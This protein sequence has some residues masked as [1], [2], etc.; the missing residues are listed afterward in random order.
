MS[1]NN[2]PAKTNPGGNN[3]RTFEVFQVARFRLLLWMAQIAL[4]LGLISNLVFTTRLEPVLIISAA[5]AVSGFAF[6]LLHKQRLRPSVSLLLWTLLLTITYLMSTGDGLRDSAILALPAI[7]V[8]SAILSPDRQFRLMFSLEVIAVI[9][10]GLAEYLGW[11]DYGFGTDF[12]SLGD[13]FDVTIILVVIGSSVWVLSA[14]L[15]KAFTR[16]DVEIHRVKASKNLIQ[17]INNFD[18]LTGLPNRNLSKDRFEQSLAR[19]LRNQNEIALVYLD[20]DNFKQVSDTLGHEVGDALLQQIAARLKAVVRE[21]DTI[22]RQGG[23]E[24]LIIFESVV[25]E[26]SVSHKAVDIE[27]AIRQPYDIDG[28]HV[29]ISASVGIALAPSDGSEFDTVR[30]HAETA[31]YQAKDDGRN[32]FRFFNPQMQQHNQE[33]FQLLGD[34]REATRRLDFELYYQPKVLLANNAIIGAEALIRWRH[35]QRGIVSPVEFISLAESYGLIESIGE[36][37]VQQACK[38]CVSWHQQ[39]HDHMKIAVNLSFIQFRSFKLVSIIGDALKTAGLAAEYLELEL[40]ESVLHE[41]SFRVPEQIH[42]INQLGAS[43]SIDDFGTGYSN[44]GRL[45]ELDISEL[46]IDRSFIQELTNSK[47]A[48]SLAKGIIKLADSLKLAVVA[49]GIEDAKTRDKLKKIGC[50]VGQGFYWSPPVTGSE[51]LRL[52]SE[53]FP[54][55]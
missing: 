26:E 17:L 53:G 33:H 15:N 54:Q 16:L 2:L 39:G 47:R 11:V 4:F 35:P 28:K 6:Y 25:D 45:G 44:L 20:L 52:L 49:E 55:N 18:Q 27:K 40:T 8:Y 10:I 41:E 42:E 46:K 19:A 32:T 13:I 43:F 29:E 51:F 3:K 23:D 50:Q 12:L 31:M 22:S 37:V 36:W 30:K 38:D 1:L 24:F 48:K 5:M 21:Q 9:M 14:D 34:L 7:L